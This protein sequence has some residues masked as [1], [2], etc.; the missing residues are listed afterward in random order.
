M[1]MPV[2]NDNVQDS[3]KYVTVGIEIF[4]KTPTHILLDGQKFTDT[5]LAAKIHMYIA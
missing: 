5:V 1:L 2:C 3:G 4:K